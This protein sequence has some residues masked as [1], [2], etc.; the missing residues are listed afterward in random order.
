MPITNPLVIGSISAEETKGIPWCPLKN[1]TTPAGYT[2]LGWYRFRYIRSMHSTSRVT[3]LAR[4]SATLAGRLIPGSGRHC[5]YESANRFGRFNAGRATIPHL[6]SAVP[7]ASSP[8]LTSM[9]ARSRSPLVDLPSS[10][11]ERFTFLLSGDERGAP[12]FHARYAE[13]RASVAI[14]T[15]ETLAGVAPGAGVAPR[16]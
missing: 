12:H 16:A 4:T 11:E 5:S 13:E 6:G 3:W 1:P 8:R 15:L 2:S 7:P 14:G 9:A 10:P